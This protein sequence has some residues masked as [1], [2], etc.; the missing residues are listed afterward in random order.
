MFLLHGGD[1]ADTTEALRRTSTCA[2][3]GGVGEAFGQRCRSDISLTSLS[4]SSFI[5]KQHSPKGGL[6]GPLLQLLLR[7]QREAEGA[8]TRT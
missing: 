6:P 7:E 2:D 5:L 3:V 8:E 4:I 1:G